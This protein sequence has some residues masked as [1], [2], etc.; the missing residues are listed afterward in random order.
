M[1]ALRA[2]F[3]DIN[4]ARVYYEVAG[5]G[6]PLVLVHAGIA[7]SRMWDDQFAAFAEQYRTVRY[8]L[9][10]FGRTEMVAGPFSHRE[11][12]RGLLGFLGIERAHLLGCSMGGATIVD[13]ALE[14]PEMVS[15]LVPVCAGVSGNKPSGPPPKE[16]DELE[17]AERAGDLE[18][19][20][21]LE[22]RIW[23]DGPH[24]AP[25]QVAP[26]IRDK[27]RAMNLSALRTPEDLGSEQ[28]LE[29]PAIGRLGELR[30]PTL[31]VIGDLD[32]PHVVATADRLAGEVA[33][34]RRAVM[35]GTAHLPSMERPTEFNRLALDFL[36]RVPGSAPA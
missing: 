27:V 13:F 34:A 33:G 21:E 3:A 32:Q 22:V 14:R 30:A 15:A 7:D 2:G 10:G 31:V 17:A 36:A 9:R 23:V 11:D 29:P 19:A 25:D 1:S 5:E 35:A 28:R 12:L 18:R 4:G 24:R 6:W 26:A 8:D 16:W 20:S